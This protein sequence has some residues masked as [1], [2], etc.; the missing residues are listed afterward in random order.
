MEGRDSWAR[1]VFHFQACRIKVVQPPPPD[2][3]YLNMT[4]EV[5]AG[6][7]MQLTHVSNMW[8]QHQLIHHTLYNKSAVFEKLRKYLGFIAYRFS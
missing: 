4:Q 6:E 3:R 8:S 5:R 7:Q 1:T 2:E